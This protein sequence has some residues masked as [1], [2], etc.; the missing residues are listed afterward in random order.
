MPDRAFKLSWSRTSV[1]QMLGGPVIHFSRT[2]RYLLIG[3]ALLLSASVSSAGTGPSSSQTP[4]LVPNAAG[5]AFV[6]ILTVGDAVKKSH[7]GNQLY[8][9]VGLPD[10]LGAFDHEH[11]TITVLMNHELISTAGVPRDHGGKGA[12]VSTWQVRQSDLK[13]L[14]GGDLIQEV[15]LWNGTEFVEAPGTAFSRFCSANLAAPTAFFNP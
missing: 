1:T 14:R 12:F 5:V 9:M 8:N 10:G 11:G 7:A 15:L 3:A 2:H 4:Y 13:V 6:S